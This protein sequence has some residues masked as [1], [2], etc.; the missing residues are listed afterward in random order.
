MNFFH[1]RAVASTFTL[2]ILLIYIFIPRPSIALKPLD[3]KAMMKHNSPTDR[4]ASIPQD[5]NL[6]P[7]PDQA[8]EILSPSTIQKIPPP[9]SP[10]QYSAMLKAEY[11]SSVCFKKCHSRND[12]SPSDKTK[13]QWRLLIEKNGHDIYEKISWENPQK[14]DYILIYLYENARNPDFKA[15][16]VGVWKP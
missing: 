10:E 3:D 12:F 4:V 11:D 8:L 9:I 6:K 16:G 13:K 7:L 14:K 1:K 2:I 15:E 5:Q